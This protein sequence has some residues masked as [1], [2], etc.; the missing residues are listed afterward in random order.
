MTLRTVYQ[1]HVAGL[2]AQEF[3]AYQQH[4][5]DIQTQLLSRGV[6]SQS[7]FD[8]RTVT[9]LDARDRVVA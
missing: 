3:L 5:H 1:Q 8:Q 9:F 6:I 2:A 7:E 4:A